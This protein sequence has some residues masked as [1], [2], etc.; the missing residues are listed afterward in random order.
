MKGD[1]LKQK[2][3]IYFVQRR[4]LHVSCNNGRFYNGWIDHFD[5]TKKN[6]T[7][8]DKELGHIIILFNEIVNIEPYKEA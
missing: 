2:I 7:F 5:T 8:V 4:Y 1:D 6:I 3:E